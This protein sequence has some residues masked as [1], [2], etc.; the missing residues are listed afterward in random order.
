[1]Q[2]VS[3]SLVVSFTQGPQASV[4]LAFESQIYVLYI[5]DLTGY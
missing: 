4:H 3:L 1:M 2:I 5:R